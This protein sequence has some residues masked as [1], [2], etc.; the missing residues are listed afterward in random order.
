MTVVDSERFI[1]ADGTP[2]LT[3]RESRGIHP[4]VTREMFD[5][6]PR[7]HWPKCD[8]CG[9]LIEK[10]RLHDEKHRDGTL[11]VAGNRT[12]PQGIAATDRRLRSRGHRRRQ[13]R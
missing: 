4:S 13:S 6:I 2:Q 9:R 7:Y 5:R 11:S 10:M 12:D 1:A 8:T 3:F